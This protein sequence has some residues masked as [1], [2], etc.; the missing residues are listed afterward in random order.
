V[1]T[2][3]IDQL[4]MTICYL[5]DAHCTIYHNKYNILLY[6]VAMAIAEL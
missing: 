4:F 2:G 6:V 1:I 3:G 5:L